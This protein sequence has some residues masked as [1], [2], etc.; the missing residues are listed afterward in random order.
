MSRGSWLHEPE[1]LGR[2][3]GLEEN[4]GRVD[5]INFCLYEQKKMKVFEHI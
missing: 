2:E 4:Q 3:E 5:A 1:V